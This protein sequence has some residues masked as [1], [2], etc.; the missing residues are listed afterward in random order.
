MTNK[1]YL[2]ISNVFK[3]NHD[4]PLEIR[5]T[6]KKTLYL[7]DLLSKKLADKFQ[8]NNPQFNKEKFI[9]ACEK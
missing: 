6:G 5:E 3:A 7:M 8:E 2:L 1:D 9:T 4:L